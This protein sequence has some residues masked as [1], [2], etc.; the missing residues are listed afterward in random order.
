MLLLFEDR[1]QFRDRKQLLYFCNLGV[2]GHVKQLE[3]SHDNLLFKTPSA[4]G[5]RHIFPR[6]TIKI[7][8]STEVLLERKFL[9]EILNVFSELFVCET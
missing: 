3:E 8:I 2:S 4:M 9:V 7:L 1:Y 6:Q 5:E